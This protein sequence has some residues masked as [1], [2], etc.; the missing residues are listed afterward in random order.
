MSQETILVVDDE[1]VMRD[2]LSSLLAE[3]GYAVSVAEAGPQG[4]ALARKGG[5][6]AAIVDVMLPEMGGIEVLEELKRIDPDFVVLMITAFAS[7]ETA[8][9]ATPHSACSGRVPRMSRRPASKISQPPTSAITA[10][11]TNPARFSILPCP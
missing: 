4:L 8:I 1:E 5:F 9:T 6:D 3:A 2:V 11:W 10:V 7:V